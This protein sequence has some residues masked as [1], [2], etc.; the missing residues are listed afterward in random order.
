MRGISCLLNFKNN[1]SKNI[2]YYDLLIRQINGFTSAASSQE[3]WICEQAV[4]FSEAPDSIVTKICEGYQFTIT[5]CGN[6]LN[7]A[8]LKKELSSFGYHFLTEKD[9]ELALFSYIHFGE[10]C[11][12][13]L[14]GEFSFIIYDSMRRQV[15]ALSSW[16]DSMPIFYAKIKDDYVLSSSIKGILSHPDIS[17]RISAESLLELLSCQNR[18]SSCIF[19][20]VYMLAPQSF[21]KISKNGIIK[22][23][24]PEPVGAPSKFDNCN[25]KNA[26]VISSGTAPDFELLETITKSQEKEHLRT[27]VYAE[28]FPD[29][30][31][32]F[33][34]KKQHLLIDD[35]T[36][37]WALESSVSACGFPFL[38]DYD[39]LLPI[40]LK[41]AKGS[42]ETLFYAFPDRILPKKNYILTLIKNDAFYNALENNI[43]EYAPGND[44]LPSY[45]SLIAGAFETVIKT[46][47]I[48]SDIYNEEIL[49]HTVSQR[50][51]TALRHILL[52]I[53]SK[54]HSPIIAFFKR[55]ALLRLCE[56]G[57]TFSK[58][59]SESELIAYLIKLNMW[60]EINRPRIV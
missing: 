52:D 12:Q 40:A 47:T 6:I 36:V 9:A 23:D 32:R 24:Y 46:P 49:T 1:L 34:T 59:Q 22:G 16:N 31:C 53:I 39:Y 25:V 56:G 58:N 35:G 15:F 2:P 18:I 55:S 38:S 30:F 50:I 54:E 26:G 33:P 28:K 44:I 51:K 41:R 19:E 37:L 17:K 48:A 10:K 13:K 3:P 8:A 27:S 5:F 60:F 20:D 11:G 14:T 7:G 45:P 43:K 21:L 29:D 57:F 42:N 4:L